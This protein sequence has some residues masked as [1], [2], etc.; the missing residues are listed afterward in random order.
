MPKQGLTGL[1]ACLCAQAA[2]LGKYN[3]N[4]RDEVLTQLE[5]GPLAWKGL[6]KKM[7]QRYAGPI[8]PTTLTSFLRVNSH[9]L[10]LGL[11]STSSRLSQH[12]RLC[13]ESE[14]TS[15]SRIQVVARAGSTL[16]MLNQILDISCV[17]LLLVPF[18]RLF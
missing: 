1:C 6:K 3:I 7:L 2:M 14:F 18:P 15:S 17:N 5:D 16:W 11:N 8:Q 10:E 13:K 12:V 9:S 4:V